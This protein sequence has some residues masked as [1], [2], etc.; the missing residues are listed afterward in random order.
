MHRGCSKWSLTPYN[1]ALILLPTQVAFFERNVSLAMGEASC[2]CLRDC[3]GTK[4]G[5]L[6]DRVT[7]D[8][9]AECEEETL[10]SLAFQ[11]VKSAADHAGWVFH[12]WVL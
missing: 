1:K 4:V 12:R 9:V 8:P 3:E 6:V 11:G 5:T 10:R 7:L 2:G